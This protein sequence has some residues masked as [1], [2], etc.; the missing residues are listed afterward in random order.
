MSN[1]MFNLQ[2]N[3]VCN[4][5]LF[6]AGTIPGMHETA[7]RLYDVVLAMTGIAGQSA[8]ASLLNE[9]PQT[10]NNWEARGV[11]QGGALK[12]QRATG[13]DANWLLT[14]EGPV[15]AGW[16][17][18]PA[19]LDRVANLPPEDV[20]SLEVAMWAHLREPVPE[21]VS[22]SARST[23]KRLGSGVNN[24]TVDRKVKRLS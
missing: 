6:N 18:S 13:C 1:T 3:G 16:P 24:H 23:L 22:G 15:L 8:V 10:V 2:T 7:E 9:S 21:S 14:G 5:T 17:F 12:A 19:L 4:N 11:S 20:S